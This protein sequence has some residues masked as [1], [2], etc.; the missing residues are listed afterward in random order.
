MCNVNWRMP[1]LGSRK[2]KYFAI[3][4]RLPHG[5]D[6]KPFD[7]V[8]GRSHKIVGSFLGTP[9][10]RGPRERILF[11]VSAGFGSLNSLPKHN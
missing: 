11:P 2:N 4:M 10:T 8:P 6:A 5:G 3:G 9:H 7:T 1:R